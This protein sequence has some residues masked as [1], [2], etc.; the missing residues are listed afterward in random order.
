MG[1]VLGVIDLRQVA[2]FEVQATTPLQLGG[3]CGT[4]L[5]VALERLS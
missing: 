4:L 3:R 5:A 2:V 1:C